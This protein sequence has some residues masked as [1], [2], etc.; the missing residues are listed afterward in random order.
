MPTY[1]TYDSGLHWDDPNLRWDEPLPGLIP[2]IMKK[3]KLNVSDKADLNL[4]KFADDLVLSMTGNANF[5]TPD[6]TL[7]TLTDDAEAIRAKLSAISALDSQREVAVGELAT[8]NATARMHIRM[9]GD[10]VQ[11]KSDGNPEKIHS[12]GFQVQGGPEALGDLGSVQNLRV[13]FS[14]M[15]GQLNSRWNK[16][17]GASSYIVEHAL[18]P[19]GPW[20]QSTVTTRVSHK[21]TGLTPGQKYYVRVCAVGA[22][23]NGPWSDLACKMAA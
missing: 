12:A 5:P 21:L 14:D 11:D 10:Y 3:V 6:P 8:L 19:L 23:G 13:A 22:T 7:V 2:A 20:T 4:A 1:P 17:R 9:I 18:N 15:E 16:V